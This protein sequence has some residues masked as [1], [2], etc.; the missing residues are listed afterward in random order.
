MKSNKKFDSVQ[1]MRAIRDHLNQVFLDMSYSEEKKYI[2]DKLKKSR[3]I[4][5]SH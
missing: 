3:V 1:M 2:N 5:I 4:S